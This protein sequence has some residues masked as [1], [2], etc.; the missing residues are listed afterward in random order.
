MAKGQT[1]TWSIIG[2][3]LSTSAKVIYKGMSPPR[4]VDL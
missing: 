2:H 1:N 3:F 4:I